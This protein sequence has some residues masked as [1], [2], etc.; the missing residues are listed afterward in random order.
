[1]H[2]RKPPASLRS[3][4]RLPWT[5]LVGL[6]LVAPS[7]HALGPKPTL[8]KPTMPIPPVNPTPKP[9]APA[10]PASPLFKA[11]LN[12][13]KQT[14]RGFVDLHAHPMAHLGFGGH[15]V[16]GAPGVDVLM[17]VGQI[18]KDNDCNRTPVRAKS[19]DQALGSCYSAHAGH[20]FIK[21]KCGNHIRRLVLNGL[22]DGNHANKPHDV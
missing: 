4:S 13:G 18:Y 17:P 15:V 11:K 20:D 14:L 22:E 16:H 3:L 19:K 5:V 21:N 1:M 7:S 8:P 10:A 6:A 2:A 12:D 9:T